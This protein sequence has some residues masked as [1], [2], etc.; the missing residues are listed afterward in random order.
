MLFMQICAQIVPFAAEITDHQRNSA[1]FHDY[2]VFRCDFS[3]LKRLFA[4]IG[5]RI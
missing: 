3:A 5:Q 2:K 1:V 4:V